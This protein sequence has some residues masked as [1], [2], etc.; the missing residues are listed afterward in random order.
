MTDFV[1]CGYGLVSGPSII[2]EPFLARVRSAILILTTA[3]FESVRVWPCPLYCLI[4]FIHPVSE[5]VFCLLPVFWLSSSLPPSALGIFPKQVCYVPCK[6]PLKHSSWL[7]SVSPSLPA[8]LLLSQ[9]LFYLFE[10]QSQ[11]EWSTRVHTH[12]HPTLRRSLS[13]YSLFFFPPFFFFLPSIHHVFPNCI[14]TLH[15]HRLF[16]STRNVMGR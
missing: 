14:T 15:T 6:F 5:G 16:L 11:R 1:L 12:T 8:S 9:M 7:L 10:K 3:V 13:I 4:Q 2:F